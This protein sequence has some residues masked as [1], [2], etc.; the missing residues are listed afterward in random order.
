VL[1]TKNV[2]CFVYIFKIGSIQHL[3]KVANTLRLQALPTDI[4]QWKF[5]IFC[6]SLYAGRSL[7][8]RHLGKTSFLNQNKVTP[9]IN[10]FI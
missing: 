9:F 8:S 6:L 3:D 5:Y 10:K 4:H 7:I 1:P 2:T